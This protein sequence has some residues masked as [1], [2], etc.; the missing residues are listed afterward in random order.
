MT[1]VLEIIGKLVMSDKSSSASR[2][3]ILLLSY[4]LNIPKTII[5]RIVIN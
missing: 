3:S 4:T 2:I 5:H 1:D